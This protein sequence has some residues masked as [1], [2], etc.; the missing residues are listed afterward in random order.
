MIKGRQ[1]GIFGARDDPGDFTQDRPYV[2]IAVR[3]SSAEAFAG[4]LP[5]AWTDSYPG[6]QMPIGREALHIGT[7]FGDHRGDGRLLQ[8]RDALQE[9]QRLLKRGEMRIDLPLHCGDGLLQEVDMR[10]DAREQETMMGLDS[11]F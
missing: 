7:D 4:T 5:I 9:G 10:Q 3:G 6:R 8:R 2:R 1:I 11:S